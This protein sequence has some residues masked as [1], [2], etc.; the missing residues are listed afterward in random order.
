VPH[1]SSLRH[2]TEGFFSFFFLAL[3]LFSFSFSLLSGGVVLPPNAHEN[4]SS[5]SEW[6][7][8]D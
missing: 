2:R 1:L 6:C 5:K 8:P 7:D 4:A 3:S